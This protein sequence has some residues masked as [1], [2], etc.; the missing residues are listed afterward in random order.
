MEDRW[1]RGG[2]RDGGDFIYIYMYIYI[3]IEVSK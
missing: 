2:R 1:K 3:E